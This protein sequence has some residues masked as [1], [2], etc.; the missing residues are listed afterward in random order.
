MTCKRVTLLSTYR[1]M[2]SDNKFGYHKTSRTG[3]TLALHKGNMHTATLCS[4][5]PQK[6]AH[7]QTTARVKRPGSLTWKGRPGG[8][9]RQLLPFLNRLQR[10]GCG[11][12][13]GQDGRE[14][15]AAAR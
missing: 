15:D 9:R 13:E 12:E 1:L 3:D 5:T 10:G 6:T 4:C 11:A 2:T 8:P 14:G 7:E